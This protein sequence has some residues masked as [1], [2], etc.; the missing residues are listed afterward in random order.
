MSIQASD[1]ML[2]GEMKDDVRPEITLLFMDFYVGATDDTVHQPDRVR[3]TLLIR[4]IVPTARV[5]P[6]VM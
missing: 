4:N 6:A 1:G 3:Q 2:E 5:L